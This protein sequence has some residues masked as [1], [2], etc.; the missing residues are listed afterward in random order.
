MFDTKY[1]PGAL[2]FWQMGELHD[3]DE[4]TVHAM[5]HVMHYGSSVF[6]GIRA[7]DT[8]RG[9]AIFRLKEHIDRF[10]HSASILNME[11]PYN[12]AEIE[13]AIKLVMRENRLRSAY[14][15]PN[16]YYGYGNLGLVPK[17]S[18]IELSVGCWGW[19]AYLGEEGV[20]K[21][22]HCLLLPWKRIHKSQT[23][24]G[25]K[26]GGLYVLSNRAGTYARRKGYDEGIFLNMEGRVSEGP[27]E[28]IFVVKNERLK[29]NSES[30]SILEGI[31][32][33][34]ILKLAKDFGYET[35]VGPITLEELW[36]ADEV[37][38]TGTAAEVTP[39]TKITDGRDTTIAKEDCLIH[40]I[41]NG[42]PG[43]ITLNM[44]NLYNEVVT[45][46]HK[47]YDKWLTYVYSCM[48]EAERYLNEVSVSDNGRF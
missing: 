42:K 19:G 24:M 4:V 44:K 33:T 20:A 17:F 26:L 13:A 35:E 1:F 29:T 21:G 28:N 31:T 22:V 38:F 32:R 37:F 34:T 40:R 43:K 16:L 45:G 5:S 18:K 25:A 41:G 48:E 30:E 47:K 6:E 7:Y 12:E 9:P 14:I 2:K 36:N 23:D 46:K 27:G 39:V 15:R 8:E 10:F 11:V 3:W